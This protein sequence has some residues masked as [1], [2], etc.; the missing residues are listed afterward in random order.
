MQKNHENRDDAMKFDTARSV[1]P[2]VE[3]NSSLSNMS[4]WPEQSKES[5]ALQFT[6]ISK[7]LT[8]LVCSADSQTYCYRSNFLK[9]LA[10][11]WRQGKQPMLTY[12]D[13][14]LKSEACESPI[15]T[16]VVTSDPSFTYPPR[17][18]KSYMQF[19]Y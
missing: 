19:N 7:Q 8:D 3:F 6:P 13:S 1:E 15:D 16:E 18:S 12:S 11:A 4:E 14:M 5:K 10:E 2:T 17:D 9:E